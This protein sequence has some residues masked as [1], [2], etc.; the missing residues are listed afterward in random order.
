MEISSLYELSI[1]C[2]WE[3][4]IIYTIGIFVLLCPA[5]F[6]AMFALVLEEPVP[7]CFFSSEE[8]IHVFVLLR[9]LH[10]SCHIG[11]WCKPYVCLQVFSAA[12]CLG[13]LKGFINLVHL[14]LAYI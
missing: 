1:I 11:S 2:L 8:E 13:V 7:L 10:G 4:S 5:F 12:Y 3:I 9:I 14:H 6:A